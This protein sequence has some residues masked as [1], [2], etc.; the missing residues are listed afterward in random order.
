MVPD[1][2][3]G[4]IHVFEIQGFRPISRMIPYCF[5]QTGS[6]PSSR[7][8]PDCI[9]QEVV[10]DLSVGRIHSRFQAYQS[11]GSTLH[12]AFRIEYMVLDLSVGWIHIFEIRGSWP[13]SRKVP[14][15]IL[16]FNIRWFRAY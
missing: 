16:H 8:V 11:D 12:F 7:M 13:F 10:P 6:W 4:R 15:R 3:V 9:Y 1:L 5:N 2:S 14:H